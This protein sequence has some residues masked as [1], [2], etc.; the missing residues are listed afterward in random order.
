MLGR[1]GPPP[2]PPLAE[3]ADPPAATGPAS[4]TMQ[5]PDGRHAELIALG[6]AH[7]APLLNRIAAELPAAADAVSRFW[8]PDWRRDVAVVATGSDR[9]FAA[10]AGGGAD[11]AAA[12]T[13]E[14][15]VFAPG[16]ATMSDEDLRIVVR[17]ELFHHAVRDD[18]AADAP[19]WLTEGVA[20]YLA[21]P[22]AAAYIADAQT[23]LPS[24]RDLDTPG[25]TRALAYDRAWRFASYVA[26]RYGPQR[27][28]ALYVQACGPGH[29]DVAT[30]VRDTLGADLDAVLAAWR[31][32]PQG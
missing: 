18:T 5:L 20:D 25:P 28:R 26:E 9:Q 6:G 14:R 21:R 29:S 32:W 15:I 4:T 7:S 8:G 12:T 22:P 16:A 11:I 3:V 2:A 17:H 30:A 23:A 27:L 10:L 24:D 1:T 13:A 19:R 31:H